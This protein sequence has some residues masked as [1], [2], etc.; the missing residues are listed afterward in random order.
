MIGK[1][2]KGV[3]A[4][5]SFKLLELQEIAKLNFIDLKNDKNKNK[6]KKDLYDELNKLISQINLVKNK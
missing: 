3:K 6:S 2:H 1:T 4:L 5:S